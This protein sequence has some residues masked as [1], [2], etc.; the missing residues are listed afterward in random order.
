MCHFPSGDSQK[1]E[2]FR[3]KLFPLIPV[4]SKLPFLEK[5]SKSDCEMYLLK[6]D[7][8]RFCPAAYETHQTLPHRFL[9]SSV[10]KWIPDVDPSLI[11]SGNTQRRCEL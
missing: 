2:K 11:Y 3:M 1:L 9:R 5:N 6:K 8:F 10:T 4:L 7:D